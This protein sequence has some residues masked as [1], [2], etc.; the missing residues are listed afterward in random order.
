M[1]KFGPWRR[2]VESR[3]EHNPLG[4][5][6]AYIANRAVKRLPPE[7][8]HRHVAKDQVIA[9]AALDGC[10]RLEG[11]VALRDEIVRAKRATN[12]SSD[13]GIVVEDQHLTHLCHS[14]SLRAVGF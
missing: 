8:R 6:R 5:L 4:K 9:I 12:D 11:V 10:E 3:Y 14:Q 1:E 13:R 2:G 7:S